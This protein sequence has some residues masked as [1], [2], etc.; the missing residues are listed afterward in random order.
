M[1]AA[2]NLIGGV[3]GGGLLRSIFKKKKTEEPKVARVAQRD[4]VADRI[5]KG[6]AL[7][8]RRGSAADLMTGTSGAEAAPAG[9]VSLLGN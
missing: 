7:R 2:T 4:D 5:R 9:I 8:Q 1:K 3:V 6:D